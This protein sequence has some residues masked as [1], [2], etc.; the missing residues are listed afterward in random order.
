MDSRQA[1]KLLNEVGL[2]I[3]QT[4]FQTVGGEEGEYDDNIEYKDT[5]DDRLYGNEIYRILEKL[6]GIKDRIDYLNKDIRTCGILRKNKQNYYEM[7]SKTGEVEK[8]YHCGDR[9]EALVEDN[10]I[11]TWVVSRIEHNGVDYYITGNSEVQLEGLAV[12]MR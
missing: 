12:R 6:N 1:L 4:L 2:K 8:T 10:E 5:P 11:F 7:V 9:I 3:E